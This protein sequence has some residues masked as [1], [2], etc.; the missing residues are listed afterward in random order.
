MHPSGKQLRA[1]VSECSTGEEAYTLAMTF[2]EALDEVKLSGR[3][4]LQIFATDLNKDA[5]DKARQGYYP[6]TITENVTS[7]RIARLFTQE[8]SGYRIAKEIRDMVIFAPQNIITDAPFTKLDILACR[9]LL[10]YF[11]SELQKRLVRLFHCALNPDGLLLLDTSETVGSFTSLFIPLDI[12]T[13]IYNNIGILS[14][15]IT[16]DF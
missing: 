15:L 3:F 5:I 13:K 16:I 12:K 6:A 9:N 8:G 11:E 4:S 2:K 1:W 10:I 14:P 7:L